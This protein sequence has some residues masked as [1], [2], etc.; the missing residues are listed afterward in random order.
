[1]PEDNKISPKVH[2]AA[3]SAGFGGAGAA[4]LVIWIMMD[5]LG[6]PEAK[7]TPD[8]VVALTGLC[9]WIGGYVGGWLKSA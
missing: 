5:G 7:F 6:I 8:R 3:N 4:V 9:A 2:A 1:M